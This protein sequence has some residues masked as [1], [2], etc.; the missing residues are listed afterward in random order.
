MD[1]LSQRLT[2][3]FSITLI[4]FVASL[5]AAEGIASGPVPAIIPTQQASCAATQFADTSPSITKE[6]A[7]ELVTLA[8]E[9]VRL[10]I[11]NNLSSNNKDGFFQ[12]LK[13]A[14]GIV[15][16]GIVVA[17]IYGVLNDSVTA[18]LEPGYFN[19][20]VLPTIHHYNGMKA[21]GWE[22]PETETSATKIALFWGVIATWWMGALLGTGVAACSDIGSL[23]PLTIKDLFPA[24]A[25]V[26]A[27][28][29][30]GSFGAGLNE[31]L[32]GNLMKAYW[33]PR[34]IQTNSGEKNINQRLYW[35]NAAAHNSGYLLGAIGG[36]FLMG[37]AIKKRFDRKHEQEAF[38]EVFA[39]QKDMLREKLVDE[40]T[41]VKV[42]KDYFVLKEKLESLIK[43]ETA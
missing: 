14:G 22:S 26:L 24:M 1:L 33:V 25:G 36:L 20:P 18:R 15:L 16:G 11:E 12:R 41:Q 27:F 37:W 23:P 30:L 17:V 4:C 29:G 9:Y 39:T 28:M 40:I 8:E 43:N 34:S 5:N 3:I 32:N 13:N 10:K 31:Y 2:K 19:L 6:Q 7:A 21:F 38:E 42:G 35:A